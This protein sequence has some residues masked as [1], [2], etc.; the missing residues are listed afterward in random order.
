MATTQQVGSVAASAP[1]PDPE[2]PERAW[3]RTFSPRYKLDILNQ[4]ESLNPHAG[5]NRRLGW[6]RSW[7][8]LVAAKAAR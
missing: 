6:L 8:A 5:Q 7:Q 1:A 3:N 4:Y 2:V